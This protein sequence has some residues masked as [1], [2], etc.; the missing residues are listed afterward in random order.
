[1]MGACGVWLIV[2]GV[3][4]AFM[5]PSLLPE[6]TQFMGTTLEA[7]ETMVPGLEVWLRKVFVVMGGFMAA[8]GVL[9]LYLARTL[10]VVRLHGVTSVFLT[11]GILTVALMSAMN[12]SLHSVFRWLLLAPVV[13]WFVAV[14]LLVVRR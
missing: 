3:Y 2:L 9:V 8:S 11:S 1:M 4:F 7:I 10:L 13:L 6:D 14:A 5:R 12:F